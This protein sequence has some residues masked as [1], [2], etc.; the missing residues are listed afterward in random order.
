MSRNRWL[1]VSTLGILFALGLLRV[2]ADHPTPAASGAAAHAKEGSAELAYVTRIT[3]GASETDALPLVIAI[4]GLGDRPEDFLKL[5]SGFD[6]PARIVA[7]RAP[8]PWSEGGSWYP[9]DDRAKKPAVI[10]ARADMLAGLITREQ[11]RVKTVGKAVVLGFSQGGVLSFAL[12]AYHP[13][14]LAAA[15]PIA[16]ALPEEMPPPVDAVRGLRVLA[17]H[18]QADRRMPLASAQQTVDSLKAHGAAATLSSYPGLGH[19]ISEELRVH[20][21]AALREVLTQLH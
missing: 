19:Q 16:G 14:L 21:F 17:F 5:F 4:H 7:P 9:L 6:L 18:G 12:A 20:L 2:R 8:D 10:R 11:K 3:G 1:L 15:L 13:E